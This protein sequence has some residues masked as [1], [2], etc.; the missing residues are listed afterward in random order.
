MIENKRTIGSEY[1]KIAAEYLHNSGYEILFL[2]FRSK[3][4]EID[5]IS[6]DGNTLVFVEVKYRSSAKYGYPEEAVD[7]R[8]QIKIRKTAMYY[9][10][11]EK[12]CDNTSVRFDVISI[13]GKEIKHIKDAF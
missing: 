11:K 13:L 12:Y 3:T 5:I 4:G 2:N 9:M 6:M 8:K 10:M 7:Y 1:E